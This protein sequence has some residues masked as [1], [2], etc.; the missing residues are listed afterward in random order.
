MS[1]NKPETKS[2]CLEHF[3]PN[4]NQNKNQN[5]N[6][7]SNQNKNNVIN[8]NNDCL[9]NQGNYNKY[10]KDIKTID[11]K[12]K[13]RLEILFNHYGKYHGYFD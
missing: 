6:P 5:S 9:I 8:H 4:K 12:S 2:E 13:R 10:T 11:E 3:T 7:T 1:N